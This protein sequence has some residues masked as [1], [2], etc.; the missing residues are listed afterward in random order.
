MRVNWLP[1]KKSKDSLPRLTP[2]ANWIIP[3]D[4]EGGEVVGWCTVVDPD[5]ADAVDG[6]FTFTRSTTDP[7]TPNAEALFVIGPKTGRVS[8]RSS[9]PACRSVAAARP[10]SRASV[11]R[12]FRS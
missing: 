9:P 12:G 8:L 7:Q 10:F 4:A 5:A 1:L 3:E 6:A 2:S 11:G